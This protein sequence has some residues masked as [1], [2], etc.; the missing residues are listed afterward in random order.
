AQVAGLGERNQGSADH[1]RRTFASQASPGPSRDFIQH[2]VAAVPRGFSDEARLRRWSDHAY[3]L[4][5]SAGRNYSMR[6]IYAT[7]AVVA[8]SAAG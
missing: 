2:L 8:M 1:V 5:A 7:H 6:G 3:R 4:T